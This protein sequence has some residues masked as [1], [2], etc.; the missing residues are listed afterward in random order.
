MKRVYPV[1]LLALLLSGCFEINFNFKTIVHQNGKID[2]EV[3]INGEGAD[4]FLPPSDS[5]WEIKTA[6]SKLG[7]S[8]LGDAEYHIHATGHFLNPAQF[9]SDFRYDIQSLISGL[10]DEKRNALVDELKIPEPLEKE[11]G[12]GNRIQ[13]QKNRSLFSVEYSYTEVFEIRHLVSILLY[14]LKKDIADDHASSHQ[15]V[16]VVEDKTA[17]SRSE[18][19]GEVGSQ[20]GMEAQVTTLLEPEKIEVLAQEELREEILPKFHF[21]SEVTLP[22]KIVASNATRTHG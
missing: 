3:Q 8:I 20:A 2:R 15:K 12:T 19:L 5:Q 9:T 17:E 21:H 22:G 1:I 18:V 16:Q 10:T 7:K 11:I 14:D 13:I 6:E 4:R